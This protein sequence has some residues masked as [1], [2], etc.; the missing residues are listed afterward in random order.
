MQNSHLENLP[1]EIL[2]KVLHYLET[3]DLIRVSLVSQRIR[4]I[5]HDETLWQTMNIQ[6]GKVDS[7]PLVD[8]KSSC[9]L[10]DLESHEGSIKQKVPIGLVELILNNGCEHLRFS[11]A[12]LVG[13]M[14]L[15][16]VSQ[17]RYLVLQDCKCISWDNP[18]EDFLETLMAS[19]DSLEKISMNKLPLSSYMLKSMCHENGHSLQVL[20]LEAC[21]GNY[22]ITLFISPIT[23]IFIINHIVE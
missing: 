21:R 16:K 17:L 1:N 3:K 13:N 15:Y 14:K 22:L 4:P 6:N 2:L 7:F 23:K 19:C 9:R 10:M 20:N 12:E 5:C 8:P 11:N 18:T